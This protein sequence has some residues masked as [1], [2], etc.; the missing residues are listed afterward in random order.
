M[1]IAIMGMGGIGGFMGGMLAKG[2]NDVSFIARG[3]HLEAIKN[4]GLTVNSDLAGSFNVRP[5]LATENAADIGIVDAVILAVKGY[6]LEQAAKQISPIVGEKTLILPL[7]NSVGIG[8]KIIAALGAGQV[9]DGLIYLVSMI[10]APGVIAQKGK[11][12]SVIMG[13][14]KNRP[15]DIEGMNRLNEILN[16]AGIATKISD[17]IDAEVWTKFCFICSYGCTGSFYDATAGEI[18]SN[19]EYKAT[20]RA[21]CNEIFLLA[22]AQGINVADDLVESCMTKI[23]NLADDGTSSLHRDV[24]SNMPNTEADAF[25]GEVVRLGKKFMIETPACKMAADKLV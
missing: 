6:S 2:G 13:Q 15:I 12:C 5:T 10:E 24:R 18:K 16:A 25:C 8:D 19:P 1:K 22:R 4:N 17:D 11:L 20:A 21:M 14:S 3:K 23:E 9:L 7:L